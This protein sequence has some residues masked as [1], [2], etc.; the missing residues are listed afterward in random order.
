MLHS[1]NRIIQKIVDEIITN[2]EL[3]LRF[4]YVKFNHALCNKDRENDFRVQTAVWRNS[5]TDSTKQKHFEEEMIYI[6]KSM[7]PLLYARVDGIET[8]EAEFQLLK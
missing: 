3:L 8:N 1:G 2:L 6:I 7:I 4:I 5:Q